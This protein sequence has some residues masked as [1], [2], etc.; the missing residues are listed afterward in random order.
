MSPAAMHKLL[1]AG[2]EKFWADWIARDLELW[3]S[4]RDVSHHLSA[5]GGRLEVGL[6]VLWQAE[7]SFLSVEDVFDPAVHTCP[8]R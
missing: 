8:I 2:G 4:S 3:R 5:Y 7:Y 6:P 1:A